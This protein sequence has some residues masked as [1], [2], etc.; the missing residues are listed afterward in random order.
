VS[1]AEELVEAAIARLARGDGK[2]ALRDLGVRATEVR[3]D[4][5]VSSGVLYNHFD[6]SVGGPVKG[7]VNEVMNR[8]L[9]EQHRL[10]E[11]AMGYYATQAASFADGAGRDTLKAA[12]LA[13]EKDF[14]AVA[15]ADDVT[16]ARER[17][18]YLAV[19]L[20]DA[21]TGDKERIS[22]DDN[23]RGDP[24][25]RRHAIEAHTTHRST[26]MAV[27]ETVLAKAGRRPAHD[28]D[29]L[30]L[31]LRALFEGAMLLQRVAAGYGRLTAGVHS[32]QALALRGEAL[33]D[34]MMRVFVAMSEPVNGPKPDPDAVL[35][36]S[37]RRSTANA[38]CDAVFY[39]ERQAMLQAIS[40]AIDQL[41]SE[42]T[43]T[44]CALHGSRSERQ[45]V[46]A[47]VLRFLEERGG[48]VRTLEKI[49]TADQ[50]EEKLVNLSDQLA[51]KHQITS[52]VLV[53]KSPPA[54]SLLLVGK[55]AAF[56]GREVD[57]LIVDAVAFV[58]DLGR[59]W[60]EAQAD[61]L[62]YDESACTLVTPK[63]RNGRGIAKA[64]RQLE[65][66][67]SGAT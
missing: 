24:R 33:V 62:W 61:T 50:L 11:A 25:F 44:F 3:R 64:R 46:Q 19:A 38:D 51:A 18:Y 8:L 10:A 15:D 65:A 20:A 4:A 14:S 29:R 55:Q 7:L 63:G 36:G 45:A 31:V 48:H 26:L 35:F 12:I 5:G 60:C 59:S 37:P 22:P 21:G 30:E 67:Q 58:D 17:A 57:G 43:L 53:M 13:R 2:G 32:E 28:I 27:Y 66:L 16:R 41:S 34:A 56:L 52:R 23:V 40:E 6:G 1:K 39:R 54:M 49:S 47:A 42:E 9:H